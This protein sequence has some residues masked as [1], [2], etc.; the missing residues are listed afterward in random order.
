MN[1]RYYASVICDYSYDNKILTIG[2]NLAFTSAKLTQPVLFN[3]QSLGTERFFKIFK[4][5]NLKDAK[6]L[7]VYIGSITK[8]G[9]ME[10]N[11]W[12]PPD[13][14]KTL[15]KLEQAKKELKEEP[16]KEETK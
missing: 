9:D 11:E 3:L 10:D 1:T 6:I 15:E 14:V 13:F 8:C 7:N 5:N 16:K 2:T 4:A 12:C